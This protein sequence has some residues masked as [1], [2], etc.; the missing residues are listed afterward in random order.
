MKKPIYFVIGFAFLVIVT[1]SV[2]VFDESTKTQK[3]N[4]EHETEIVVTPAEKY[5]LD[6]REQHCGS[7]KAKTNQYIKEFEIPT[8]CTQPLSIIADPEGKIWF[9]QTNTGKIAMFDPESEEFTEYQ[10]EM[11]SLNGASMMWGIAYTDDNE[12]WFTDDKYGAIWR[13]SIPDETYSKFE[14][15]GKT[16]K[17]FP[18]KIALYNDNFVINDFTGNQ[19]VVLNHEKLDEG[20]YTNS[21]LSI[22]EGFFTSQAVVDSEGNMWFV[23]WKYQKE[24][25]LVKTNSISQKVEQY[26]LPESIQAPNGVAIGPLG[27]IWIADTAGN[28]FYKFNPEDKKVIEFVTSK[29]SVLTYG[30][31]SG[32]IKTPITRPYW[33][34]FDSDGKMW[35]NQQ[36]GNRLAVFDPDSE[37]LIEYDIPS[38]NP[39]WSDCG[40]LT[41]CGLSQSFGFA[42]KD[43]QVWFTEWVENNIGVLDT[44][45]TIPI[46]LEIEKEIIA[47]KQGGQKEI[48]VTAIPQTNQN[49][50]LVL[51]GNSNSELIKIKT[52]PEPT[53]ISDRMVKIPILIIVDEKAHQGD[54]KILLSIQLQ[55][56]VVSSYV[57][58]RII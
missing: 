11:W 52:N 36:T 4:D 21:T 49:I 15:K 2:T 6:E 47:I 50:D 40:D 1:L 3:D 54:Y 38:K 9:T 35:F 18:Q 17:A 33:N 45:I 7:S 34:A 19:M 41:D 37:S 46:S 29:P 23:M 56:V 30:N 26:T 10:N 13:F 55:D 20:Q 28:S 27:G 8:P 5:S 31:A 25:I 58:V 48:F 51:S 39:S 53:Q 16:K 42:F 22:P 12:I 44:S 24:I 43:K 32:L 14:I 57:S